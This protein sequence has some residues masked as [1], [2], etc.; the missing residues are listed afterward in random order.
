MSSAHHSKRIL[1]QDEFRKQYDT[2]NTRVTLS[3]ILLASRTSGP[4]EVSEFVD[5]TMELAK[6][7]ESPC[8]KH[9]PLEVLFW[10]RQKLQR[11]CRKPCRS[12]CFRS[13]CQQ[14]IHHAGDKTQD[15]CDRIGNS[16]IIA[17]L[18]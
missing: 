4:E 10:L 14:H 15:M 5:A 12:A 1:M 16:N 2:A 7:C 8:S 13:Y 6:V 11:E 17:L 3:V 18:H 9:Q